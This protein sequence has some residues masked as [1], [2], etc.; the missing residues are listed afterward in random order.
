MSVTTHNRDGQQRRD[1]DGKDLNPD[2]AQNRADD[3]GTAPESGDAGSDV[4]TAGA[5]GER[6]D[7]QL[8]E[9]YRRG[10]RQSFAKLVERYQ[11]ELFHFLVR[12]LGDRA[13]AEDIFQETFLQIHQ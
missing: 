10:D 8:L 5:M 7:E 2:R 9:A 12:F 1:P 11:R 3:H 4:A 13:A 6:T